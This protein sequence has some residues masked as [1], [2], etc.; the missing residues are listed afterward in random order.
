MIIG[1]GIDIIEVDRVAEK[2]KKD[3]GF[4]EKIFSFDEIRNCEASDNSAQN[5]A[6]RFAAKEAFLK[7]T[8]EGLALTHELH[9][10]EVLSNE[11]GKPII[12]LNG[13]LEQYRRERNW[14][15]IHVSISHI[16][17]AATAV[18]IIES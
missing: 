12:K 8:G 7:A 4:R 3:N 5:Y 16:K 18:V 15:T 2:I 14:T 6:G 9:L 11:S 10:I 17:E 13:I 1:L